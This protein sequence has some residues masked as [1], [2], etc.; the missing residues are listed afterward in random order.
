MNIFEIFN[1]IFSIAEAIREVKSTMH[2]THDIKQA[3]E[4]LEKKAVAPIEDLCK[5]IS[6]ILHLHIGQ[7]EQKMLE[8]EGALNIKGAKEMLAKHE[9]LIDQDS[10]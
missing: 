10:K 5:K 7:G 2:K 1:D 8:L 4:E 3:M 9:Q 6:Q